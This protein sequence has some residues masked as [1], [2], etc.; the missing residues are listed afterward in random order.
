[1]GKQK[2]KPNWLYRDLAFVSVELSRSKPDLGHEHPHSC[3]ALGELF[4]GMS[5]ISISSLISASQLSGY[6]QG[7]LTHY[8]RGCFTPFSF[9]SLALFL[10]SSLSLLS[11]FLSPLSLSMCSQLAYTPLFPPTPSVS[12]CLS[13]S[14]LSQS[15]SPCPK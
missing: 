7:C 1:M 4:R 14:L 2:Q 12:L 11:P 6:S 8:K 3:S 13:M 5:S 9:S 10:S 15:P